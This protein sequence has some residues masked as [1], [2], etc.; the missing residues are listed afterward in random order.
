MSRAARRRE[1]RGGRSGRGKNP[2]NKAPIW[3]MGGSVLA[4]LPMDLRHSPA[5]LLKN[6]RTDRPIPKALIVLLLVAGGT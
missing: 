3:I 5:R 1:N 2:I 4:G 6:G